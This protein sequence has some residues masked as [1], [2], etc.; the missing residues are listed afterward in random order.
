METSR[1]ESEAIVSLEL[2]PEL[3]WWR[4]G[5]ELEI[6]SRTVFRCLEMKLA[7]VE[8]P[9]I[10]SAAPHAPTSTL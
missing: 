2:Q 1:L 6:G 8:A 10:F 7:A 3:G 4:C 9:L 5:R